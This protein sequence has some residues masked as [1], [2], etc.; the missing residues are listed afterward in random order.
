MPAYKVL[1]QIEYAK[2]RRE[3]GEIVTDIPKQSIDW[4]LEQGIITPV[5]ATEE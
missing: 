1:I 5:A 4:L 2:V 3:P